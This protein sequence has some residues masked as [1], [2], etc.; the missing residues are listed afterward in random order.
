[1]VRDR[2]AHRRGRH[3]GDHHPEPVEVGVDHAG[4][5][6]EGEVAVVTGVGRVDRARQAVVGTA[7][8]QVALDLGARGVGDDD[9][10]RGVG[11]PGAVVALL[12]DGRLDR[13]RR[14]RRPRSPL[15]GRRRRRHRR[16]PMRCR[17][18]R[19][20]R[21]H[22]RATWRRWRPGRRRPGRSPMVRRPRTPPPARRDPRRGPD[23]RRL[24]PRG[25]RSPRRGRSAPAHRAW[26][27]RGPA[28]RA[29][30]SRRRRQRDRTRIRR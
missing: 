14:R 10:Q 18:H 21:A 17:P 25:R 11:A 8:E 13:P 28:R 22:P 9:R 5:A 16:A 3:V 1:M 19:C 7:G 29:R 6:H 26:G 4:R 23:A 24:P 12:P 30:A 20:C 15:P 27:T 2:V